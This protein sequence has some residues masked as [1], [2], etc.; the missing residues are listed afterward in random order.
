MN[1]THTNATKA[2]AFAGLAVSV[3]PAACIPGISI[4]DDLGMQ[5]NLTDPPSSPS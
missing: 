3:R 4:V 2:Y 1:N 5:H